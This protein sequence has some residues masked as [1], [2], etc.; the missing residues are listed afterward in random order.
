[1]GNRRDRSLQKQGR[2]GLITQVEDLYF[3]EVKHFH[4]FSKNEERKY[5]CIYRLIYK[6][7]DGKMSQ[8]QLMILIFL[9]KCEAKALFWKG[10]E[11]ARHE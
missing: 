1:M 4:P 3:K 7:G 2:M 11:R 8:S 10:E 6:F 9:V 5:G